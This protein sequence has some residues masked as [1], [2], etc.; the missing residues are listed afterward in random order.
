MN[1]QDLLKYYLSLRE[2]EAYEWN[3]SPRSLY[4]ELET[5]DFLKRH[6]KP[7]N[8][9]NV[10]NVGIGIGE[11]DDY[12]GYL[13]NGYGHLTSIDIDREICNLFQYRQ[14]REGHINPSQVVCD[15][16]TC[17]T[18]QINTY[19]LVTIIGSTLNQIGKNK[20]VLHK[21][22]AI[23][24]PGGKFYVMNFKDN[25][26]LAE[27]TELAISAGFEMDIVEEFDRYPSVSF[28]CLFLKKSK[29]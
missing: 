21:T 25:T 7:S 13:I 14:Q 15:D 19:D 20:E 26:S 28:Y 11:W 24:K 17:S 10:C 3:L 4:L 6:Y 16:Y 5:R 22:Y 23:L 12:L 29:E 2:S 18:L 27:L 9:I 8:N 1:D